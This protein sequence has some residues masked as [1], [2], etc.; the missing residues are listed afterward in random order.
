LKEKALHS[1][2]FKYAEFRAELPYLRGTTVIC[3]SASMRFS[4]GGCV[5]N[6]EDIEAPPNN[7]FTMHKAEVVG[8]TAVE[9]ML[10]L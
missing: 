10:L 8:D 9:G 5:L 2:S 7:G 4:N 3:R 1:A 6:H